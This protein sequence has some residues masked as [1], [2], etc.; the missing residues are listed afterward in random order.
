MNMAPAE[1]IPLSAT[2]HSVGIGNCI[3]T[4]EKDAWLAAYGLGSCVALAVWDPVARLAGMI[5]ILLPEPTKEGDTAVT[6]YAS[7]GVPHLL[8]AMEAAG[9]QRDRWRLVAAGGA[10]MLSALVRSGSMGGIGER[11]AQVVAAMVQR[12]KLVLV[13]KDF[14][15]AAGRTL[16]MSTTTGQIF[17]RTTGGALHPL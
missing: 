7:T 13:A 6:R 5:H 15:G 1:I 9:G 11:N 8:H 3:V 2:V 17:V 4:G 14:G 10:Q 16:S 12:E